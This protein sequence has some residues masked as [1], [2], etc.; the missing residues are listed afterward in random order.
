MKAT[1]MYR[2]L[3][4]LNLLICTATQLNAQCP[5]PVAT[6]TIVYSNYI[7]G[8]WQYYST[9]TEYFSW[10]WTDPLGGMHT[11]PGTS[12]ASRTVPP[13]VPWY[14]CDWVYKNLTND[15]A[16]DNTPVYLTTSSSFSGFNG[17]VVATNSYF[18][19]YKVLA[20]IYAAPGN[21]TSGNSSTINYSSGS[22]W[23]STTTI[24]QSFQNT[25]NLNASLGN[26]NTL[27]NGS[28]GLGWSSSVANQTSISITNIETSSD[29]WKSSANGIDHDQ[30]TVVIWLNPEI[31]VTISSTNANVWSLTNNPSDPATAQ[32]GA[33]I[34]YLTIAQLEGRA[35]ITDPYLVTKLA[36][37]WVN[38]GPLTGPGTDSDFDFI[39]KHDPYYNIGND[40]NNN[41]FIPNPSRFTPANCREVNYEPSTGTTIQTTSYTAQ[42]QTVTSAQETYTESSSVSASV[43]FNFGIFSLSGDDK[44]T[45]T[46]TFIQNNSETASTS[47]AFSIVQP[48]S[49]WSGPT[50]IAVYTDNLYGTF[51]FVY[52]K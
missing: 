29:Q 5:G 23:G 7:G 24:I 21:S 12:T 20:V 39:A 3:F 42:S 44:I 46:D 11:F 45:W 17:S 28:I 52:V 27:W 36:R 34:V 2:S 37:T 49:N 13:G 8:T 47:A 41:T 48:P 40:F 15:Q 9:T 14:D 33:D 18:P 50:G 6:E 51:L 19:K 1:L 32:V 26:K 38:G 30:D 10:S 16:S 35:P 25:S 43:G 4:C 22:G 31:D